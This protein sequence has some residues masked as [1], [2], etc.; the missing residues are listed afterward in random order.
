[1]KQRGIILELT[2]LLD[3]IMVIMFL[4]LVQSEG[5]MGVVYTEARE[6]FDIE[7]AEAVADSE[8]ATAAAIAD[9][10]EFLAQWDYATADLQAR[11]DQLEGLLLGL[12][13]DTAMIMV[14]LRP[15]EPARG[16]RATVVLEV[17]GA[18]E[19]LYIDLTGEAIARENAAAT[20]NAAL[21]EQIR[22][23]DSAAIFIVYRFDG[24]ARIGADVTFVRTAIHNQ[25][26]HAPE[27]IF[28]IEMNSP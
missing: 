10:D 4:I 14:S 20:L 28:A 13:E 15:G 11:A 19:A 27:R 12:E 2:P 23:M 21:A 16:T 22:R 25:R 8:A 17:E 7:L 18:P 9:L 24:G 1:M 3:V 5:R 6:A 26:L